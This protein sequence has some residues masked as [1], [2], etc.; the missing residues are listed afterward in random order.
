[1]DAS[2]LLLL[3]PPPPLPPSLSLVDTGTPLPQPST[4]EDQWL[5]RNPPW[6][7]SASC[8]EQPMV[9]SLSAMKMANVALLHHGSQSNKPPL[10]IYIFILLLLL[11]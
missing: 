8:T 3:L 11:L 5:S 9:L 6:R 7:Q 2:T 10:D 1:M 4:T